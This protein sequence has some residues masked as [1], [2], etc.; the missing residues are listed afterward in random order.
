MRIGA[1]LAFAVM[2]LLKYFKQKDGL[3]DPKGSLSHTVPSRAIA[4]ANREVEVE[5][6]AARR[7]ESRSKKRGP[8]K[9]YHNT[10][11]NTGIYWYL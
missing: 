6:A 3:P 8:Y 4:R 5:L 1:W 11:C 9:R 10:Q 2:S 7:E